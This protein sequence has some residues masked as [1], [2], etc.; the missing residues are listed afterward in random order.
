ML[1][2]VDLLKLLSLLMI[3]EEVVSES[4]AE[5]HLKKIASKYSVLIGYPRQ[6]T[7]GP[8]LGKQGPQC[9]TQY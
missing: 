1:V 9:P 4:C 7:A 5:K 6:L 3:A 8:N 2:V